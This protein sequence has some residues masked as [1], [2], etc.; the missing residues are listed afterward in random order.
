MRSNR[1]DIN[2]DDLRH[3]H[4]DLH[5]AKGAGLACRSEKSPNCG[6]PSRRPDRAIGVL[7][8]MFGQS[9]IPPKE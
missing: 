5:H 9:H 7:G 3:E 6:R 2:S 8:K 4:R 1:A